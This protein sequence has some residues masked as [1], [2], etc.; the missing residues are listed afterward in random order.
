MEVSCARME[1]KT[2][3]GNVRH[4]ANIT[5]AFN[6][7]YRCVMVIRYGALYVVKIGRIGYIVIIL[8]TAM[9]AMTIKF[10]FYNKNYRGVDISTAAYLGNCLPYRA[11][12]LIG[13]PASFR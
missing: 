4:L 6:V 5:F 13:C 9:T 3:G 2:A 7:A 12:T 10:L 11:A 8:R 1:S